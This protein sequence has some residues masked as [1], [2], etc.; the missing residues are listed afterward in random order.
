[1][2]EILFILLIAQYISACMVGLH[3]KD[4][5]GKKSLFWTIIGGLLLTAIFYIIVANMGVAP[6]IT[7]VIK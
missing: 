2:K 4:K 6:T 1:M 7:D 3:L 5:D